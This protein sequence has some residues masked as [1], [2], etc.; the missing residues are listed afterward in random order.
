MFTLSSDEDQRRYSLSFSEPAAGHSHREHDV[1]LLL[2]GRLYLP[3]L[4]SPNRK[5][6]KNSCGHDGISNKILKGITESIVEPLNIV[7][8]KSVEEGVF[9]TEIKKADTV[10]LYKSKDKDDKNNYRPISLLLTVSKL[11]EKIMYMS[12]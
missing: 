12:R 2:N 4:I 5:F 1:F 11:L 8:N 6:N 10:P 7:F 3:F 9:P